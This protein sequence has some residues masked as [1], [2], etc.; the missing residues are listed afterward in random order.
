MTSLPRRAGLDEQVHQLGLGPRAVDGLLDGQHVGVQHCLAQHLHD[1][2]ETLERVVQQHVALLQLLEDGLVPRQPP[3]GPRG[4]VGLE[5]QARRVGLVDELVQSHQVDRAVDAVQR[6]IGQAELLQQELRQLLRAAVDHLQPHRAAEVARRQ[7]GAQRMAQVGD[8]LLVHL[9]VGV[10][11]DAELRERLDLAAREQ[12]LQVRA[13]D[14]GQQRKGLAAVAEVGRQ[15]DDARQHARHLDDGDAVVAAEGVL[16]G[17]AR[18]EVQRL[19]GPPAGKGGPGSSPTGT[20]SGL[21]SRSKYL[22]TQ[23]ALRLVAVGMVEHHDA[24]LA[25]Q[26]RELLVEDVVL[27]VD[28]QVRRAAHAVHILV[29][30]R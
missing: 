27:L 9:Q 29:A 5:A 7:P 15:L 20:S 19:V 6:R 14:A 12:L 2:L 13:D 22:L 4:L 21:T 10:A 26:R 28:Q 11:R 30:D 17:Q 16:A 23:G 18:N 8:L 1:R 25:Q 3:A 24:L